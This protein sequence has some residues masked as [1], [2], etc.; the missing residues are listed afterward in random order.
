MEDY[1]FALEWDYDLEYDA[2]FSETPDFQLDGNG[3]FLDVDFTADGETE[4][5]EAPD[6]PTDHYA[7]FG[8]YEPESIEEMEEDI[9]KKKPRRDDE[10]HEEEDTDETPDDDGDNA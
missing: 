8:E 2:E 7:S 9:K 3:A 10:Y 5:M 4:A 6:E 1:D